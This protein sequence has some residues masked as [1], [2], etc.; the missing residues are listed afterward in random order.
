MGCSKRICEM[1]SQLLNNEQTGT[2]FVT[3]RFGNVLSSNGSVIPIFKKQFKMGAP[4]SVTHPDIIRYFML[5]LE[6][7]RLVLQVGTMGNGG[8]SFV[9]DIV[10]PVMIADLA[11]RMIMLSGATRV[12]I[13]YIS[14][15]DGE[16]LYEELL[17]KEENTK[18]SSHPKIKFAAVRELSYAEILEQI[19]GLVRIIKDGARRYGYCGAD[20]GTVV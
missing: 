12:E 15:R 2:Q 13:K 16:K 20:E 8:E 4:L 5:I 19:A 14:L 9:F 17:I 10:K 7:C 1:Y 6:A 3:T 18:P 11:K